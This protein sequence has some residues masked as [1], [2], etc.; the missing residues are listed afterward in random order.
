MNYKKTIL[1]F[2]IS[3]I[4]NFV[5][6]QNEHKSILQEQSEFYS[7][8]K[9]TSDHQWDS[10]N[11]MLNPG[12]S[13]NILLKEKS[14][15]SLTKIVYGWHPYWMGST[16]MNYQWNLLSHLCYFSY[17]LD[18]STGNATTTNSWSTADAVDSALA[19]G[20]KVDLC[21]TLMNQA[22][23]TSFLS[24]ATA[25]QTLITN[26]KSLIQSRGANG[27]NIDFEG[28]ASSD[29]ANFK[30]FMI[31]LCNQMHTSIPGSEISICL[32]AVEWTS[33]K[34]SVAALRSYVDM[35]IIMGYDYYYGGSDFAGP[36]DPLYNFQTSYNYTLTKSITYYLKQGVPLSK[37]ILGLPY[38]GKQWATKSSS[39]PDSTTTTGTSPLYKTVRANTSGN[40]SN[41][42]WNEVS[43]TPYYTFQTSG[44]WYQCWINDAFSM[45]KRFEMVNQRGIG[46]IGIWALG[47]DD[48]YD[49]YW[50]LISDKFSD[51][52]TFAC[53]D[54]LFDMGGPLRNY[55][56]S[57]N[58][59]FTLAPTGASN[60]SLTFYSF[61]TEAN[62][63][64]L[65]IYDGPNT[66][67]TL[68]GA[69]HGTNSPGTINSTGPSLTLK[70]KSDGA[71]VSSGWKAVWNCNTYVNLPEPSINFNATIQP[72]P[73]SEY[74][75]LII[76]TDKTENLKI[77]L[78]DIS[79]KIIGEFSNCILNKGEHKFILDRNKYNLKNGF[80][81]L[82]INSS[83]GN[84]YLK[85]IVE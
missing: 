39:V 78:F 5:I 50:N 52:A 76:T 73:F 3:I 17:E 10:L 12:S 46:G 42:L 2:F 69:F 41:K 49:D 59:T 71:T 62:Y 26:L 81:F 83:K 70:F 61:N 45:G 29:S 22:N 67:S 53:S 38:Y 14:S 15:C 23:L 75:T 54:T 79:G 27:V 64:T 63:D 4:S 16:Y 7:K 21:V 72:N 33:N 31:D 13:Q 74:A 19:N 30:T 85:I 60:V 1:I 37:L 40:Y 51:C 56:N 28:M 47:Y 65:K 68:I 66:S 32:P 80:Y 43:Y 57:E 24:N 58:Y 55:Y 44:Q 18:Y 11:A 9:F 84:Q 48:G 35:F 34:Y 6:A 8:Y 82:Q 77:N 20:V 36:T 25:R